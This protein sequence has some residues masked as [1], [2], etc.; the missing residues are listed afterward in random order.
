MCLAGMQEQ[1]S[2]RAGSS[3]ISTQTHDRQAEKAD[4]QTDRPARSC[5]RG[6]ADPGRRGIGSQEGASGCHRT[7]SLRIPWRPPAGRPA[8]SL[9][10]HPPRPCPFESPSTSSITD[11]LP[12]ALRSLLAQQKILPSRRT[13]PHRRPSLSLSVRPLR[14]LVYDRFSQKN[15]H[16]HRPPPVTTLTPDPQSVL[17]FSSCWPVLSSPLSRHLRMQ[18]TLCKW[19]LVFGRLVAIALADERFQTSKWNKV[20]R[21]G[22]W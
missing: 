12:A 18:S 9:K 6:R 14:K 7:S 13:D 19:L 2:R 21:L 4:S 17:R 20:L 22:Y 10:P 1:A 11:C 15:K 16:S 5:R 3:R 8:P